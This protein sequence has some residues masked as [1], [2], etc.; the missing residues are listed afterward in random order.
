[1][2]VNAWLPK[3][4]TYCFNGETHDFHHVALCP[5]ND[6]DPENYDYARSP[7][8][9]TLMKE[10]IFA[11]DP[12]MLMIEGN[13]NNSNVVKTTHLRYCKEFKTFYDDTRS[14]SLHPERRA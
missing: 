7:W 13:F 5:V 1:M 2:M 11:Y 12:G 4:L 9:I 3:K 8:T 6:I 10:I 14:R